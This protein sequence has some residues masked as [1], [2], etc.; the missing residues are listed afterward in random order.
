MRILIAAGAV[1]LLALSAPVQASG[2][3]GAELRAA[4]WDLSAQT[5]KTAKKVVKKTKKPKVEYMRIVPP[6]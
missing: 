5:K 6:K 2:S 4:T 1:A 3:S